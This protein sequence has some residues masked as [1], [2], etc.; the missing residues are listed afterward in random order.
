MASTD[1]NQN[2]PLMEEYDPVTWRI[3]VVISPS[4]LDFLDGILSS[5]ETI[6][7]FINIWS[8]PPKDIFCGVTRIIIG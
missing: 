2:V 5:Y 1:L 8:H 7:E 3:L 4:S 6:L